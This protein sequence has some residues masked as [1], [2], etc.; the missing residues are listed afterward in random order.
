MYTRL[1]LIGIFQLV[2]T[3]VAQPQPKT[4]PETQTLPPTSNS[5]PSLTPSRTQDPAS[6]STYPLQL[7]FNF[8]YYDAQCRTRCKN[9]NFWTWSCSYKNAQSAPTSDPFIFKCSCNSCSAPSGLPFGWTFVVLFFMVV[10][11][12]LCSHCRLPRPAQPKVTSAYVVTHSPSRLV[13]PRKLNKPQ[14]MPVAQATVASSWKSRKQST[15]NT[16]VSLQ[17]AQLAAKECYALR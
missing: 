11:Y 17:D 7:P 9:M 15:T 13:A 8:K 4:S 1:I 3:G 12:L 14:Q 2:I 16:E 10:G 6:D 5:T